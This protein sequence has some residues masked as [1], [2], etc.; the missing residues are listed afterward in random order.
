MKISNNIKTYSK[1]YSGNKQKQNTHSARLLVW[2]RF[3]VNII[4]I[5]ACYYFESVECYI[6]IFFRSF[7]LTR[8]TC[9]TLLSTRCCCFLVEF[10]FLVSHSITRSTYWTCC[11]FFW[12]SVCECF[13]LRVYIFSVSTFLIRG[14]VVFSLNFSV[15]T[16]NSCCFAPANAY[17][18]SIICIA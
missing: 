10:S 3:K 14:C 7:C 13:C 8:S 5:Y 9:L 1:E 12:S 6:L 2:L 4:T 17:Q 15:K 11:C 16:L 18:L